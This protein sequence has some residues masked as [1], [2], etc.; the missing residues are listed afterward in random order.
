MA[1]ASGKRRSSVAMVH[2][3][4]NK[5]WPVYYTSHSSGPGNLKMQRTVGR[6]CCVYESRVLSKTDSGYPK[7]TGVTLFALATRGNPLRY[8]THQ[9]ALPVSALAHSRRPCARQA[10]GL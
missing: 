2:F 7:D 5:S 6:V 1:E 4:S 3:G 8:K 10:E 9:S